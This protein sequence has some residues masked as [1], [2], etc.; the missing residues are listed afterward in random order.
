MLYALRDPLSFVV[1]ALSFVVAVTLAGWV[2]SL[3]AGR[4]AR[5]EDPRRRRP[6]P[7]AHVD[8]FGAVAAA[9]TGVGWARPVPLPYRGAARVALAGPLVL[10]GVG[11]GLLIGVGLLEGQVSA[12]TAV[13]QAGVDGGPL[14]ARVL[15][16]AGLVHLFVGL[17]SLL[18]LPPLDGGRLL[19]AR[20]PRTPGWQKAELYLVE[21]NLGVVALLVLLLLPLAGQQ[22]LLLALLTAVGEPLVR[23]L[24]GL[25]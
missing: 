4:E 20:S 14:L 2:G 12:G 15:L 10:L 5:L 23:L 19:F 8:P 25:G 18:P 7:R 13:L 17:L 9:L 21:K 3:A 6:D 11:A 24:T 1:L 16:L 22:P